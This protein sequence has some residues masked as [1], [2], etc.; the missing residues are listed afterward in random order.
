MGTPTRPVFAF[1]TNRVL[2]PAMRQADG[3]DCPSYKARR[4][5]ADHEQYEDYRAARRGILDT[6]K[7]WH[8]TQIIS[9]TTVTA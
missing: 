7:T 5:H 6:T 2:L 1:L 8:A 4:V 3:Q 9:M